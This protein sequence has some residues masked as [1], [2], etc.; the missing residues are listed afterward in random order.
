MW[1]K[2]K[3]CSLGK[4]TL[5]LQYDFIFVKSFIFIIQNVNLHFK[6]RCKGNKVRK[7]SERINNLKAVYG[8]ISPCTH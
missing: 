5:I 3:P 2:G 7:N 8:I 1:I 6:E 4:S